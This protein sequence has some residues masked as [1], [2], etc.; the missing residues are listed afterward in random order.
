MQINSFGWWLIILLN[1]LAYFIYRFGM[2][3]RGN[4]KV[5][6]EFTGGILLLTS[7]ILMFLFFGIKSGGALI[8]IFWFVVTPIV[9]ISIGKIEK[10]LYGHYLKT[11][12]RL[13]QKYKMPVEELRKY[14]HKSDEEIVEE[15]LPGF[16]KRN[17]IDVKIGKWR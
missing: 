17:G 7:F 6:I 4:L 1:S 13:A 3:S 11:E 8:L 15:T 10:K 5:L 2:I 12:E 14:K 16:T 9:E